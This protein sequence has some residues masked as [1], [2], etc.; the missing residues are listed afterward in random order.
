MAPFDSSCS[1]D[2]VIRRGA[3]R[4]RR[5]AAAPVPEHGDARYAEP[6]YYFPLARL[7][8]VLRRRPLGKR[9]R[10][11]QFH[12]RGALLG[13]CRSKEYEI[14]SWQLQ[15]FHRVPHNDDNLLAPAAFSYCVWL[16]SRPQ[17]SR[18]F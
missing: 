15:G 1:F 9:S 12:H 6:A 11:L 5:L 3:E 17:R 4:G 13:V 2:V 18:R 8:K 16:S 10:T 7:R 14:C